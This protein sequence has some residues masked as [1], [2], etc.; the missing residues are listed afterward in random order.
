[1]KR[2]EYIVRIFLSLFAGIGVGEVEAQSFYNKNSTV[3][4]LAGT[5][6]SVKDSLVN[7]GVFINNGNLVIGGTW[8]NTG[9]YSPGVGE[10][11]FNSTSPTEPQIINHSNQSFSKL[12][13]SGGGKKLILADITI[14][15]QFTLTDGVIEAENDARV[16]IS[17]SPLCI[18]TEVAKKY[19]P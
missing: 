6:F 8:F 7:T 3:S 16:I 19:S 12:T 4:V 13:I 11:T 17:A 18:I 5:I 9:T 15:D 2:N 1:M 14:E 10:I